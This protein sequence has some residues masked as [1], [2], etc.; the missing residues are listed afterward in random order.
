[1]SP[2]FIALDLPQADVAHWPRWAA[3]AQAD[4]WLV[5]LRGKAAWKQ[6]HI[7]IQGNAIA[8]PRL[9]AWHGEPGTSY[10][11]SG[12]QNEPA[13]WFDE[14]AQIRDALIQACAGTRFNS[15]LLNRYRSGSD[16]VAWHADNEPE[17]GSCPIIASVSLGAPR[18]F[19][20]KHKTD[21][22]LRGKV[23]LSH[24]DLLV[25]RGT[26][27]RHW[28]HQI[29]KTTKAVGERINLTF[30]LVNPPRV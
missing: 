22:A 21:P 24:G 12:I 1:M 19:S 15:V 6:D 26:T 2:S 18:Q 23:I 13:P 30:R 9:T 28:L 3:S 16:S 20:F 7:R 17:L 10:G 14:L 27:Q 29:P 25:M 4:A 11:Y 5:A 8:L